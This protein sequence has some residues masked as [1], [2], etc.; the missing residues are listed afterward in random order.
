MSAMR[1][2]WGLGLLSMMLVA[3]ASTQSSLS[4]K[5]KAGD[6]TVYQLTMDMDFQNDKIAYTAKVQERVVSAGDEGYSMLFSQTESK[7]TVFGDE[8]EVGASTQPPQTWKIGKRGEILGIEGEGVTQADI[9][10]ANLWAVILPDKPVNVSDTWTYD[11][12]EDV[13]KGRIG[14]HYKGTLLGEE[15]LHEKDC[16]MVQIDFKET[17]TDMASS[18]KMWLDKATMTL[19]KSVGDWKSVPMTGLSQ[20]ISGRVTYERVAG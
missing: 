5:P 10:R 19:E 13:K 7:A 14:L 11:V 4:R 8:A 18:A 9:R 16:W 3:S 20:P 6:V 12:K 15:K 2:L 17:K 1:T